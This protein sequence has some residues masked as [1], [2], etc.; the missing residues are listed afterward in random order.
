LE[1]FALLT[2][3][4]KWRNFCGGVFVVLCMILKISR[5]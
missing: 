1:L 5:P 2:H 3:L 4:I